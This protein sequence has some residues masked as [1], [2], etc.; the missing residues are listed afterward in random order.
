MKQTL[1]SACMLFISTGSIFGMHNN[2]SCAASSSAASSRAS[3]SVIPETPTTKSSTLKIADISL[4]HDE[5]FCTTIKKETA[6]NMDNLSIS[7]HPYY[8]RNFQ[9]NQP[10]QKVIGLYLE[11]NILELKHKKFSVRPS[12]LAKLRAFAQQHPEKK[13]IRV[14]YYYHKADQK[15]KGK[16]CI[17]VD[18]LRDPW[19][20]LSIYPLYFSMDTV[21]TNDITDRFPR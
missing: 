4:D 14:T 6:Y 2:A 21:E 20:E 1:L 13:E 7:K 18:Q 9:P 3:C 10:L 12:A 15:E 17:P 5:C 16:I 11:P 19:A 8:C